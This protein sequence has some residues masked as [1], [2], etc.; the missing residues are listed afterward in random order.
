MSSKARD[1]REALGKSLFLLN[2]VFRRVR[3]SEAVG[4]H[5]SLSV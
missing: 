2:P 3:L 5:A 1:S 4:S